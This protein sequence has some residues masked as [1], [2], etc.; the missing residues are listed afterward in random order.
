MAFNMMIKLNTTSGVEP[1]G[2]FSEPSTYDAVALK[3]L[4]DFRAFHIAVFQ[5]RDTK[6]Y[7][8]RQDESGC[9]VKLHI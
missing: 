5:I 4:S 9:E 2:T 6:L 7:M 1:S 8:L 3:K